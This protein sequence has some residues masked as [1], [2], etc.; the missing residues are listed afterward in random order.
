MRRSGRC[1]KVGRQG[2]GCLLIAVVIV[3][4]GK[5]KRQALNDGG[6]IASLV[7]DHSLILEMGIA[8]KANQN[9]RTFWW[10]KS[11]EIQTKRGVCDC[12]RAC[13]LRDGRPEHIA[14]RR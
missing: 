13:G 4:G 3:K 10:L 1:L 2:L 12:G 14:V 9:G 11:R 7:G 6:A 8:D 5:I